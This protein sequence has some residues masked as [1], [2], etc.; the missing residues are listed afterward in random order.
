MQVVVL[1]GGLSP[2]REVS[3]RS[4][5]RVAEALRTSDLGIEVTES[6]V[7]ATQAE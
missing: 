5:R 1:A 2:E 4:G 3:L 7:N 6:D